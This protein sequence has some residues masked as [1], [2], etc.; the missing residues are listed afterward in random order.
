MSFETND[1]N[2]HKWMLIKW[3]AILIERQSL[4]SIGRLQNIVELFRECIHRCT[5]MESDVIS[6]LEGGGG[7]GAN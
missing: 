7:G 4:S 3:R 1:V 5:W 2:I 6:Q